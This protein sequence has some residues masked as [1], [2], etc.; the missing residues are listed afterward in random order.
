MQ[1]CVCV[2]IDTYP[3]DYVAL[4]RRKQGASCSLQCVVGIHNCTVFAECDLWFCD[5][6]THLWNSCLPASPQNICWHEFLISTGT[7]HLAV[8]LT[9]ITWLSL[10]SVENVHHMCSH[11]GCARTR[12]KFWTLLVV[13]PVF[14]SRCIP[15]DLFLIH[16][17]SGHQWL[18]YSAIA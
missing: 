2:F 13:D 10:R 11:F 5:Q 1:V 6:C 7:S 9:K 14:F 8:I 3:A 4:Q 17:R 15:P 12:N 16:Q 18:F